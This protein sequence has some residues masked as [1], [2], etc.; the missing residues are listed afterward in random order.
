MQLSYDYAKDRALMCLRANYE[1]HLRIDLGNVA[2]PVPNPLVNVLYPTLMLECVDWFVWYSAVPP[3]CLKS[4]GTPPLGM[5]GSSTELVPP[6]SPSPAPSYSGDNAL[7]LSA[8]CDVIRN[9]QAVPDYAWKSPNSV[10]ERQLRIKS[11]GHPTLGG[12]KRHA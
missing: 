11:P 8:V 4:I 3:C 12:T 2:A 10:P 5:A 1:S 6:C 7:L 9:R